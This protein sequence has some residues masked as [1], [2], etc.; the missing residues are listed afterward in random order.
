MPGVYPTLGI[1]NL[2]ADRYSPPVTL[3]SEPH[4]FLQEHRYCGELA[5][6]VEEVMPGDWQVWFTCTCGA[7][8]VRSAD[9]E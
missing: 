9:D 2:A 5:S 4:A 7:R 6:A 3:L 1:P 8:M